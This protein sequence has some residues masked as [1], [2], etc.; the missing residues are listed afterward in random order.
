MLF[1]VENGLHG[2]N[3][4]I[5]AGKMKCV[6]PNLH[7]KQCLNRTKE[8]RGFMNLLLKFAN[9]GVMVLN[10]GETCVPKGFASNKA[11][12][13]CCLKLAEFVAS[14]DDKKTLL[15]NAASSEDQLA[16]ARAVETSCFETLLKLKDSSIE[17]ERANNKTRKTKA[18]GALGGRV[19]THKNR[20][21]TAI[22]E[23]TKPKDHPIISRQELRE[24]EG[25]A[26]E[27]QRGTDV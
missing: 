23:G 24:I 21:S 19:R 27:F 26:Q 22:G 14:E 7:T 18:C 1:S 15:N 11:L 3:E 5:A 20:T 16:A 6:F 12:L 25:C 17:I 8:K 4:Q 2:T 10:C 9:D 13:V